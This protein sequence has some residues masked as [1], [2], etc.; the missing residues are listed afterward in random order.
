MKMNLQDN[1]T[2]LAQLAAE[3]QHHFNR[4]ADAETQFLGQ[5]KELQEAQAICMAIGRQSAGE[6]WLAGQCVAKVATLAGSYKPWCKQHGI[7][8]ESAKKAKALFMNIS[9]EEIDGL[10]ITEAYIKAGIVKERK[11]TGRGKNKRDV[12]PEVEPTPDVPHRLMDAKVLLHQ[13]LADLNH[14]EDK[15]DCKQLVADVAALVVEI[16]QALQ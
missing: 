12:A 2:E 1:T 16:E 3:Y 14:A 4:S 13:I 5:Q 7:A 10:T 11:A 8:Y 6:R 15:P 9:K